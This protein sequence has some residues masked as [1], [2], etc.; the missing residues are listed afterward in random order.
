MLTVTGYACKNDVLCTWTHKLNTCYG[1]SFIRTILYLLWRWAFE[2]STCLFLSS[3][4]LRNNLLSYTKWVKFFSHSLRGKSWLTPLTWAQWLWIHVGKIV[5]RFGPHT[6]REIACSL[7]A[8]AK[9]AFESGMD[10]KLIIQSKR[11][12]FFP[13]IFGL[14]AHCYTFCYS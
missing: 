9:A 7:R 13:W 2:I 14:S 3:H 11:E 12:G 4:N 5:K 1:Y 8:L 6:L 10:A